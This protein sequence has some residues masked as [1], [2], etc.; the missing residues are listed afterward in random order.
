MNRLVFLKSVPL[1]SGMLLDHIMAV[2]AAM[3]REAYL[4][5]ET[6]F[7]EGDAGDKL[8]IV[9][10]GEVSIRK[11]QAAGGE[12]ELARLSDGQVF[13][14]MALFDDERRSATVV[15]ETDTDLLVLDRDRFQSI[16]YQRPEIPMQLCR[17]L[18]QRLRTTSS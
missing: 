12:K 7:S 17:V 4:P 9:F 10:K 18:A 1:F 6:I 8:F 11:R 3:T 14:E 15:A 13:G 16:A 2:D 5:G